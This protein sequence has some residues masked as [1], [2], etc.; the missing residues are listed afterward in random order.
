MQDTFFLQESSS[1]S[2]FPENQIQKYTSK[3]N[4]PHRYEEDKLGNRYKYTFC[5]FSTYSL[6]ESEMG[7]CFASWFTILG[8]CCKLLMSASLLRCALP[9][10]DPF[11]TLFVLSSATHLF[12]LIEKSK[13]YTKT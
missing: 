1:M 5:S 4:W 11:T 7:R 6:V 8:L 9:I 2:C 10:L 12:L 3:L 13:H